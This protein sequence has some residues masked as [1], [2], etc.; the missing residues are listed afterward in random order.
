VNIAESPQSEVGNDRKGSQKWGSIESLDFDSDSSM[1]I[2]TPV[3]KPKSKPIVLDDASVGS[4]E[5]VEGF[6]SADKSDKEGSNAWSF[7]GL[8]DEYFVAST[9]KAKMPKLRIPSTLYNKLFDHQKDGVSWMAGL[10]SQR[11]GGLLGDDMGMGK[12][13]MALT[14]LGGLMRSKT[15]RNGLI[16]AP[17]SVLRSWE[18]EATKVV[19]LCVPNI[20]IL[21]V[22][23]DVGKAM[24]CKHLRTAL[25]W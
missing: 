18:T 21:V 6:S 8:R 23:S 17:L 14:L 24:R 9:P 7:D 12:T 2:F 25:T 5:I 16:V 20:T 13:Y 4:V 1:E 11:V 22:S 3:F 19:K 10:H 15:I